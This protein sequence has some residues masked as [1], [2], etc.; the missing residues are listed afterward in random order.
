MF[1]I[2]VESY[3]IQNNDFYIDIS[4]TMNYNLRNPFASL[5]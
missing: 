5:F 4:T 1:T 2:T 3:R